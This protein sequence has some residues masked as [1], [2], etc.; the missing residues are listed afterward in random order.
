MDYITIQK[1]LMIAASMRS[2]GF[3]RWLK[4]V[5]VPM[6]VNPPSTKDYVIVCKIL[7]EIL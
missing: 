7:R 2:M 6:R 3:T 5:H 4:G 1:F